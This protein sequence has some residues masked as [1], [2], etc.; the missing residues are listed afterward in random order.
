MEA[1]VLIPTHNHADT[2]L[3]SVA[4]AQAQTISDIEIFVVGDGPPARTGEIMREFESQ[5]PRVR[6]FEFPKGARHGEEHRHRVLQSARGRCV[7]YLSDDDL[8]LRTHLAHM[9][10]AMRD[11]DF[12]HAIELVFP[13]GGEAPMA[14]GFDLAHPPDRHA[15]LGTNSGF[16]L[17]SGGHTLA[18]YRQLPYGWRAAPPGIH[19]DVHMWRQIIEQPWCR[20]RS[21]PFP[22]VL[23][24]ASPYRAGWPVAKR[25][26]ELA[27]WSERLAEP[28]FGEWLAART[29]RAAWRNL[30]DRSRTSPWLHS[31]VGQLFPP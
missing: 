24:F 30:T 7:C 28:Q 21:L 11:A 17:S 16:G 5:D 18:S 15:L 8:W 22:T 29:L 1:T 6:Y 26:A 2:L 14:N 13:N 10:E 19:T 31:P 9:C 4:S 27:A 3:Y 20:A 23:K 25:L 12:V